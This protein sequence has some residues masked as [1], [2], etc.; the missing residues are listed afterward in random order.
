M[1]ELTPSLG[2]GRSSAGLGETLLTS[3]PARLGL[4]RIIAKPVRSY[5]ALGQQKVSQQTGKPATGTEAV[6]LEVEYARDWLISKIAA[7]R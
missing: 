6:V 7:H 5:T 1:A 3:L 4:G 2:R